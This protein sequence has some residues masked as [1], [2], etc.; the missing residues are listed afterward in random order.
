M[1][2]SRSI[3][4]FLSIKKNI[5]HTFH[6]RWWSN[7]CILVWLS[8][9]CKTYQANIQ[10]HGNKKCACMLLVRKQKHRSMYIQVLDTIIGNW[11]HKSIRVPLIIW[12]RVK[13]SEIHCT[14]KTS[15]RFHY[16]LCYKNI[17]IWEHLQFIFRWQ[18]QKMM[19]YLHWTWTS[20]WNRSVTGL[21]FKIWVP[22]L[23]CWRYVTFDTDSKK[24]Q[25]EEHSTKLQMKQ[26]LLQ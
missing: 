16:I 8:L 3:P 1:G 5:V 7:K 9:L 21:F 2:Y 6:Q 12:Q 13:T 20:M 23:Q 14:G 15:S 10:I 18:Q 22:K 17:K 25:K 4:V 24:H 26:E 19:V 11:S